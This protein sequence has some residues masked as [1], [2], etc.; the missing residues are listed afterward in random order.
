MSTVS[1]VGDIGAV[2][3]YDIVALAMTMG[4]RQGDEELLAPLCQVAVH[5]LSRRLRAGVTVEDCSPAFEIACAWLALDHLEGTGGAVGSFSAGD[6]S[7]NMNGN[8]LSMAQRA[9]RLM[10]PYVTE[11]G[12]AFQGV[13]G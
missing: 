13:R 10:A 4:G 7:V 9:E 12:F 3:L 2:N 5:D 8:G 6:V 1:A 11:K